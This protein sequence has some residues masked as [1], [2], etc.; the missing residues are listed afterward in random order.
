M[1]TIEEYLEEKRYEKLVNKIIN[2]KLTTPQTP[3]IKKE[4]QKLQQQL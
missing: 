2:L 4:I 3:S 1:Q